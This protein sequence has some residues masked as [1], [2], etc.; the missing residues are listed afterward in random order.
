MVEYDTAGPQRSLL[1]AWN[2]LPESALESTS[3][4]ILCSFQT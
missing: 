4:I 2:V 1:D 3:D